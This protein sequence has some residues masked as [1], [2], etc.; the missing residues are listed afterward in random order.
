MN[1][2][3]ERERHITI[4]KKKQWKILLNANVGLYLL[5]HCSF[6]V[7]MGECAIFQEVWRK[8]KTEEILIGRN[9]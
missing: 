4:K 1:E 5:T 3:K 6:N 7:A 9:Y 2:D 8:V